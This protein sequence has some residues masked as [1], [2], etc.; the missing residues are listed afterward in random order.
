MDGKMQQLCELATQAKNDK[1]RI[2]AT[3]AEPVGKKGARRVWVQDAFGEPIKI[4]TPKMRVLFQVT[5]EDLSVQSGFVIPQVTETPPERAYKQQFLETMKEIQDAVKR[6][7]LKNC[8]SLLG[9]EYTESQLDELSFKPFLKQHEQ[10]GASLKLRFRVDTEGP[11][12][13][14]AFGIYDDGLKKMSLDNPSNAVIFPQHSCFSS[15]I[16]GN[17][18]WI[19]TS[20]SMS[21]FTWSIMDICRHAVSEQNPF[22]SWNDE[23]VL[24]TE[25]SGLG[26]DEYADENADENADEYADEN[27]KENAEGK[28]DASDKYTPAETLPEELQETFGL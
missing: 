1:L 15:I 16:R 25:M 2:S 5:D 10:W 3:V 19:M 27:A 28:V 17:G 14:P 4:Q 7:I 21:G 6:H 13:I 26:G 20:N 23:K 18:I 22:S 12:R 11:G 24:K 8:K 9:R